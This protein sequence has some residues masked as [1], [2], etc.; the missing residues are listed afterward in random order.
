VRYCE[1]QAKTFGELSLDE[2]RQFA[3]TFDEDVTKVTLTSSLRSR[4]VEGGTSPRRVSAAIRRW[5]RK[6]NVAR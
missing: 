5:K 4:D 1:Q 3:P 6:L 2:Y